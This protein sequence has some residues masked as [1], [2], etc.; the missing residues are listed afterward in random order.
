VLEVLGSTGGL[1][2]FGPRFDC[3]YERGFVVDGVLFG[4]FGKVGKPVR[5]TIWS[6][7]DVYGPMSRDQVEGVITGPVLHRCSGKPRASAIGC[8]ELGL[9][10]VER[11]GETSEVRMIVGWRNVDVDVDVDVDCGWYR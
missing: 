7:D 4:V 10:I 5:C 11:S 1:F 3:D 6:E 8:V 9:E 2:E